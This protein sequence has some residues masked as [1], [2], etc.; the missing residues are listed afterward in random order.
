VVLLHV[1]VGWPIISEACPI[2]H[3][4]T[5]AWPGSYMYVYVCLLDRGLAYH[6]LTGL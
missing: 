6:P 4:S 5:S 1:L 2:G 3:F